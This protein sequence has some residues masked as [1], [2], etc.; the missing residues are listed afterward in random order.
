MH[1]VEELLTPPYLFGDEITFRLRAYNEHELEKV[2]RPHGF[3]VYRQR[4]DRLADL[5]DA[6]ALHVG[7]C[8]HARINILDAPAMWEAALAALQR[9]PFALVERI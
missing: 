5:L 2:Y 8:L 9:D 7:R 3:A 6:N 1:A 4:Y